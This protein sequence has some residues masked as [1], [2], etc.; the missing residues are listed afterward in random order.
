MTSIC[1]YFSQILRNQYFEVFNNKM[2]SYFEISTNISN[3]CTSLEYRG[4]NVHIYIYWR[5]FVSIY[6]KYFEISTSKYLAIRWGRISK[7]SQIFKQDT[8]LWHRID[9]QLV[10]LIV[11]N[12]IYTPRNTTH[13]RIGPKSLI[14]SLESIVLK[15]ANNAPLR[16]CAHP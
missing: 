14:V 4:V 15:D 9:H 7:Y 12:Y 11:P 6:H 3:F 16:S 13:R 2:F 10:S 1:E 8:L 5:V